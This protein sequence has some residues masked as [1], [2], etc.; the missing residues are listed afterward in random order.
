MSPFTVTIDG[1]VC[2]GTPTITPTMVT[3][4]QVPPGSGTGK[5]I[6]I[7][8][9]TLAPLTLADTFDY[10]APGGGKAPSTGGGCIAGATGGL[11]MLALPMLAVIRRRRK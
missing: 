1:V 8:S 4:I 6:V 11:A 5:A 7:T 3:G 2:P 9:G 10:V